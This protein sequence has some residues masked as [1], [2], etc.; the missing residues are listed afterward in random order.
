MPDETT[1][2][3]IKAE[4]L[5][6]IDLKLERIVI[7]LTEAGKAPGWKVGDAG[8]LLEYDALVFAQDALSL[9]RKEWPVR[10]AEHVEIVYTPG[11]T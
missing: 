3:S 5:D 9:L 8:N 1:K 6:A 11:E 10:P 7:N 2:R 4:T